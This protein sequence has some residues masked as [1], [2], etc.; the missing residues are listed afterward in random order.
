M[1]INFSICPIHRVANASSVNRVAEAL[2]LRLIAKLS[3]GGTVRAVLNACA[4]SEI[5]V[6]WNP[7]SVSQLS[8][9]FLKALR[10]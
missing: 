10:D 5:V 2:A 1:A 3:S 9:Q 6:A 8:M 7:A 4:Y